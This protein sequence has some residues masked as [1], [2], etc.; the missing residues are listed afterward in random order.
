MDAPL[1]LAVGN[2]LESHRVDRDAEGHAARRTLESLSV[3]FAARMLV[4]SGIDA[5]WTRATA[6]VRKAL[7]SG[8]GLEKF[9]EIIA[10]PGRRPAG[11]RRLRPPAGRARPRHLRGAA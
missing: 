5:T 2:A 11:H 1:G 3:E 7:S 6:R 8:A 4:L 10:Q 9:R